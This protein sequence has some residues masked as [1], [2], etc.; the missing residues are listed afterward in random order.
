MYEPSAYLERC[1][2]H[3]LAITPNPHCSQRVYVTFAKAVRL[4]ALLLWKQ[5]VRHRAIRAQ[6]WRQLLVMVRRKPQLLGLYLSLCAAG[7]HFW[8]YRQ[9]A[10]E[11]IGAQLGHD[12]LEPARSV[13][14]P[15]EGEPAL[16]GVAD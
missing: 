12:P 6:F 3:C 8:E 15:G 5:G 4:L 14:E 11:R 13:P 2:R 9:L 7:E 10:R 16:A 1:L